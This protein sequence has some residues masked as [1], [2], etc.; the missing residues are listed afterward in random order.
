MLKIFNTST[1]VLKTK[2]LKESWGLGYFIIWHCGRRPE[3]QNTHGQNNVTTFFL[4]VDTTEHCA[5]VV[6]KLQYLTMNTK[7]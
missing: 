1:T 5:T 4:G 6:P 7:K 2:T 3:Y